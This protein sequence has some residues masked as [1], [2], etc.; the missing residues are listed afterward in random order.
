MDWSNP[1]RH[2]GLEQ[3]RLQT[4]QTDTEGWEHKDY[5]HKGRL[6]TGETLK[7]QMQISTGTGDTGKVK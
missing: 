3:N 4:G 6:N 1:H 5:I 7:E 2:H